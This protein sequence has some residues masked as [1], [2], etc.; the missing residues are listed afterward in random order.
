MDKSQIIIVEDELIIAQD[1]KN[2]LIKLGYAISAIA[3]SGEDALKKIETHQ[4]NLVLMEIK[5]RG[6]MDGIEAAGQVHAL[7][8]VP[9]ERR[10]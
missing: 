4:P 1:I 10:L 8:D 3:A 5:L 6:E 9:Y 7:F 2:N